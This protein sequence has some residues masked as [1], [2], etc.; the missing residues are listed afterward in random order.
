VDEGRKQCGDF[1]GGSVSSSCSHGSACWMQ[2]PLKT[3]ACC[4]TVSE[5]LASA[6]RTSTLD[7]AFVWIILLF[8]VFNHWPVPSFET[9]VHASVTT[10]A[11]YVQI[12]S[13]LEINDP[14]NIVQF[15]SNQS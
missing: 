11:S 12:S 8:Y 1:H 15:E 14:S 2:S 7:R 3:S 5:V 13:T 4:S 9:M 6:L 10:P